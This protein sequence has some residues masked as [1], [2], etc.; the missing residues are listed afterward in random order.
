M[1]VTVCNKHT[2]LERFK[3]SSNAAC[4]A[5]PCRILL[6]KCGPEL[7]LISW[8]SHAAKPLCHTANQEHEH[9]ADAR[10]ATIT[11][12]CE[13]SRAVEQTYLDEARYTCITVR[14]ATMASYSQQ[15][16][17]NVALSMSCTWLCSLK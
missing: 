2:C 10:I 14:S 16:L 8:L 7:E 3:S 13:H 5:V 17:L 1:H 9:G 11:K 15:Q 4:L 12:V 6:C